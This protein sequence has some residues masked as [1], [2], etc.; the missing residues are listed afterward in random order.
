MK[1]EGILGA[2]QPFI[3][4]GPEPLPNVKRMPIGSRFVIGG[5]GGIRTLGARKGS[6]DFES[7]PFGQLW[8]LSIIL[9]WTRFYPISGPVGQNPRGFP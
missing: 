9:C 8:H 2:N 7:S 1:P 6:L 4:L 5:E 3:F